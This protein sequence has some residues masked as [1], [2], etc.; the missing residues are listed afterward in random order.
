MEAHLIGR[1]F[2]CDY[3]FFA[4]LLAVLFNLFLASQKKWKELLIFN[5]AGGLN[6][7]AELNMIKTGMRTFNSADP[8]LR[9]GMILC[10]GWITNGFV[11]SLMYVNL[12]QWLKKLYP[13]WFVIAANAVYFILLP[14]AINDWGVFGCAASTA[15]KMNDAITYIE[16]VAVL[17]LG[18]VIYALGYRRLLWR[19]LL[20]GFL[21]DLGFEGSLFLA[22]VR[23]VE[24]LDIIKVGGRVL[25]EMNTMFC[26]GF[27]VFKMIFK[28][29][30]YRDDAL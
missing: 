28:L 15:R 12:R 4:P 23:P 9:L 11:C 14:L 29:P 26:A 10:L 5:I 2:S 24:Q 25:F 18:A 19:L 1:N 30:G 20:V 3:L 6:M 27:L 21:L 13:V 22:G 7:F 17:V 8:M 16:P